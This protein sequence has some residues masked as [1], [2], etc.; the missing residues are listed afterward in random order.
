MKYLAAFWYSVVC[1]ITERKRKNF[2]MDKNTVEIY[3]RGMN[4]VI[5]CGSSDCAQ[6]ECCYDFLGMNPY[7]IRLLTMSM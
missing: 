4:D 5:W 2:L 6:F 7:S 1:T 3:F